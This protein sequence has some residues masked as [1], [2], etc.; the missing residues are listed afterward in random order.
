[1][2]PAPPIWLSV[3]WTED[4]RLP[5]HLDELGEDETGG[6]GTDQKNLGAESELEL[7][8]SVDS[9]RSGLKEGSLLVGEVLDLVA[10][11]EVAIVSAA[12]CTAIQAL[13]T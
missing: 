11:G 4:I 10:L 12:L 3:N 13:T 2:C 6:S 8:H 1:M 7:V 9:T 5:T